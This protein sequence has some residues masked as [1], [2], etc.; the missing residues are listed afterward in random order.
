MTDQTSK[1]AVLFVATTSS[2]LTPLMV[3]SV[4]VAFP[5]IQ[6]EFHIDAVLLA[7]LATSYIL[8]GAVFLVPFGKAS[9]IFGRKKIYVMGMVVFTFSSLLSALAVSAPMLI[10]FRIMQGMGSAMI[11]ATG[12]AIATSVF[13]PSERGKAIGI[14]VGAVY[15]GLSV[16]PFLGGVLTQ[17]YGWRSVF[18]SMVPLGVLTTYLAATKLKSEW[19]DARGEK[20]DLLGSLLYGVAITAIMIGLSGPPSATSVSLLCSGFIVLALFIFW[21]LRAEFPVLDIRLFTMNR[22][23]AF[24]SLAA[25]INYSATFAVTFILSLYL[26]YIKGFDPS[27]AGLVLIV[28]PLTMAAFSPIAG[29]LSDRIE[30]QKIASAG[31]G[32]T[33]A[34][35]LGLSFLSFQTSLMYIVADLLIIGFGFGLFSSPNMNAIMSSVGKKSYGIAS[36]VVGSMRMLGQMF[37]MGIATLAFSLTMGR[38]PITPK[39]Y[40]AFLESVDAVFTVCAV[41]CILGIFASLAR[42]KIRDN[43]G[44]QAARPPQ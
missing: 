22:A 9:D 6:K 20:L 2:L 27:T 5:A 12:I 23:F 36:G 37:S 29:K 42:G 14:I 34:G 44:E 13:P 8:S 38:T 32:V 41:L 21:E 17:M 24:S 10:L 26:Q 11:F 39:L 28:Q 43:S 4:N 33:A 19:A 35:L 3:S 40:P 7:W 30:P 25:L 15:I 31:M 1:R 16:G 18:G